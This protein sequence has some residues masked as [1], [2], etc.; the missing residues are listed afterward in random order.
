LDFEPTTGLR[1]RV[2]EP[3]VRTQTACSK[4]GAACCST[5]VVVRRAPAAVASRPG[6][7]V[8]GSRATTQSVI[9]GGRSHKHPYLLRFSSSAGIGRNLFDPCRRSRTTRC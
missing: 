4:P 2:L 8:A 9:I 7:P 6:P 3:F 1:A 5:R